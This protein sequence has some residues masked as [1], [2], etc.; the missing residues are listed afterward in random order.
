MQGRTF[1]RIMI[2]NL[3]INNALGKAISNLIKFCQEQGFYNTKNINILKTSPNNIKT[4]KND[5][6]FILK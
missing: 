2:E 6:K 4:T 5:Y 1:L 3:F